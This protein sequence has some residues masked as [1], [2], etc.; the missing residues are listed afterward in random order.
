LWVVNC[1]AEQAHAKLQQPRTKAGFKSVRCLWAVKSALA[2]SESLFL[3]V[4]R[5]AGL[6][7]GACITEGDTL[8]D[9][10]FT[11]TVHSIKRPCQGRGPRPQRARG[12]WGGARPSG[13][14]ATA[15]DTAS[16][17]AGGVEERVRAGGWE[18][19]HGAR[20]FARAIVPRGQ[21]SA[22]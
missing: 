3:K 9:S 7:M 11:V 17:I 5:R 20:W 13:P 6:W 10:G 19:G 4:S 1:A 2:S 14:G 18:K 21:P 15:G 16:A 22:S 8:T 12:G